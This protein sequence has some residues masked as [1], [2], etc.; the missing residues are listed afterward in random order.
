MTET[1]RQNLENT[2]S[3][4]DAAKAV[5]QPSKGKD[6]V[7]SAIDNSEKFRQM[8]E[9]KVPMSDLLRSLDVESVEFG[10]SEETAKRRLEME[11]PNTLTEKKPTHWSIILIKDF[12]GVF[13]IMLWGAATLCFIV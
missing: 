4:D 8:E 11:G 1:I 13:A 5:F 3:R 12:T 6:K 10:L 7:K 9:H 2:K